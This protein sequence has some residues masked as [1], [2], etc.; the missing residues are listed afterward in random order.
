MVIEDEFWLDKHVFIEVDE[1]GFVTGYSSSK[2]EN[3]TVA[4][5]SQEV[6]D[7]FFDNCFSY[8]VVDGEL[9]FD[10][11]KITAEIEQEKAEQDRLDQLPS[12]KERI[13]MLENMVL[14]LLMMEMRDK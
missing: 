4:F 6:P 3:T 7:D 12:D 10:D 13:E 11:S 1:N 5:F 2:A 14:D 9:T 8:R